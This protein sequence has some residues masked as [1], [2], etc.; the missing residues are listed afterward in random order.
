MVCLVRKPD[1]HHTR[2]RT[3]A[4]SPVDF[5]AKL[6]RNADRNDT[7]LRGYRM[8]RIKSRKQVPEDHR[9]NDEIEIHTGALFVVLSPGETNALH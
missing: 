1:L 3:W 8:E 9:L 6:D 2:V 5:G 7:F 4:I